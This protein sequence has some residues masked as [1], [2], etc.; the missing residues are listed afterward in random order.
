MTPLL[1]RL[2]A[3]AV[4]TALFAAC[5]GNAANSLNEHEQALCNAYS[6]GKIIALVGPSKAED[7]EWYADW[8]AY[9]NEFIAAHTN[10]L[11]V[12]Y[13]EQLTTVKVAPY[14]VAFSRKGQA[15]YAVEEAVEPQYYEYVW[16][17]YNNQPLPGHIAPFAPTKLAKQPLAKLCR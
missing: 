1:K 13:A 16:L 2:S 4:F 9:L 7:T 8:S 5:N 17:T 10:E 12:E 15:S 3:C 6:A 11:A 14:V